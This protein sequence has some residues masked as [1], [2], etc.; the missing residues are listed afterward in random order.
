MHLKSSKAQRLHVKGL[1][2]EGR[3]YVVGVVI[4]PLADVLGQP[5]SA[6]GVSVAVEPVRPAHKTL[7]VAVGS[8]V[9]TAEE[10]WYLF[11]FI[12]SV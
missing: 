12:L 8:T 7:L 2:G 1:H 10:R 4:P 5:P 3:T 11:L 6:P 9:Q